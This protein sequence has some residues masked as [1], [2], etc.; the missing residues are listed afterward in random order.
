MVKRNGEMVATRRDY[1]EAIKAV[2][3][4]GTDFGG[5]DVLTFVK[6]ELDKLDREKNRSRKVSE[7][8][9]AEYAEK[10]AAVLEALK[11]FETPIR[12]KTL[13]DHADMSS[14]SVTASLKRLVAEGKVTKTEFEG[15]SL[16]QIND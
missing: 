5:L 6:V 9:Q 15:I 8:K 4:Q 7:A 12:V 10:D 13:A 2:A 14:Q 11:D 3:E 1:F 16:Y